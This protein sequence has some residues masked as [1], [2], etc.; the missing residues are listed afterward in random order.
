MAKL[1]PVWEK[2]HPMESLTT[3]YGDG[4]AEKFLKEL[5][6]LMSRQGVSPAP[7]ISVDEVNKLRADNEDLKTQLAEIKD[8]IALIQ[9]PAQMLPGHTTYTTGKGGGATGYVERRI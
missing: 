4:L 9:K 1:R 7:N 2:N 6:G 3:T 8:M 5:E